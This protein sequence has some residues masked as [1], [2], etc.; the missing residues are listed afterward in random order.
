MSTVKAPQEMT[1][2]VRHEAYIGRKKAAVAMHCV[3][4]V[5]TCQARSDLTVHFRLL[6]GCE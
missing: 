6:T 2:H 1:L 5:E 4:D 3:H